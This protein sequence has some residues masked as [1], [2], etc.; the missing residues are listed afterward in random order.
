MKPEISVIIPTLNEAAVLKQTLDAVISLPA[1][2][3]I[4]VVDGGSGAATVSIAESRGVKILKSAPNR[5]E[6][7]H[8]G[9]RAASGGVLW[10]LH[11]DTM[12]EAETVRQMK[13]ALE[14]PEVVGGNFTICFEGDSR[15]ARF[16][17][18]LYP[19]LRKINLLY[20]D[21][22]IFARREAYEKIGGFKP[23]RLFEDLE[24]V[25]RLKRE[26][27]LVNLRAKVTTSSRRFE[28][29]SFGL[30]FA[31][32]SIFQGLYW[33]GVDPSRLAKR[34]YPFRALKDK[35]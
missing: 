20:G 10:F 32:W 31:R 24:F 6:Q 3:E 16:M 1:E 5:G 22:A 12:P 23:L 11:A 28:N 4:I 15:A 25:N 13:N 8:S 29:R 30:T 27:K 14:N 35:Y 17:T 34:Y 18:R 33:L 26:G 7:L 19:H 21:S 9:A 2:I